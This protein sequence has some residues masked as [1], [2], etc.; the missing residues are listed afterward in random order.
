MPKLEE[1]LP[2]A[3]KSYFDVA[4]LDYQNYYI[5]L[6]GEMGKRRLIEEAL[7][8]RLESLRLE[9]D[10]KKLA[11]YKSWAIGGT[12]SLALATLYILAGI[13]G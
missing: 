6:L 3:N 13:F 9:R 4:N 10:S 8:N 1:D 2:K 11:F 12:A 5:S 7:N